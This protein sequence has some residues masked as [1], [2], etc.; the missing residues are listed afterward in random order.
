MRIERNVIRWDDTV[1]VI[2]AGGGCAGASAC[3]GA[4]SSGAEVLLLERGMEIGGSSALSGGV[5]YCGGGTPIQQACGF[6][7]TVEAMQ[8]YLMAS[9]GPGP[10]TA[11]IAAYCEQSVNHFHWLNELGVPFKA[12][13]WPH[14]Y[15]PVTDDCLYYSG[16]EFSLPYRDLA[17]PAPRG[18]TVQMPGSCT[19]GGKLMQILESHVRRTAKVLTEARIHA[20]VQSDDGRVTGA[21]FSKNGQEYR[22]RARSGIVL[23]TGGFIM[24][25]E[26]VGHFAPQA[27]PLGALGNPYDDGSG[28]RLGAAAGGAT[29]NMG[30]VAYTC[31]VLSPPDL[32]RGI[33]LN[34]KGQRFIDESSNHKRIGEHAILHQEGRIFL[35][36]DSRVYEEPT[37]RM[38]IVAT[39]NTPTE[40]EEE[41]GW[42]SDAIATTLNTYNRHA[43]SGS[44]PFFGKDSEYVRPLDQPP[45][46]VFDCS[47]NATSVYHSFTLGGLMTRTDGSV[48]TPAG[49][50]IPG[51]YAAG[52]TTSCLSAQSCGS[53]GLQL[54]EGTFFGRLAGQTAASKN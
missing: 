9:T 15:E 49:E 54:G 8:A 21:V 5:V 38:P 11:K 10:D 42:P 28:I 40:L 27:L 35:L 19:G 43:T 24:D 51:L 18:H 48:L 7:D 44:D 29:V 36:V 1:D 4:A 25:R 41:L 53:S 30:S 2:V 3:L 13:Y 17:K 50:M 37:M 39:G 16:S 52:R 34:A 23:S 12:S 46:A 26:M 33:L 47:L 31:P 22:V 45:Y 6:E 20:L 32:M 14:N